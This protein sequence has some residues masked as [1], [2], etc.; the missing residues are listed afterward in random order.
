MKVRSHSIFVLILLM[1]AGWAPVQAQTADG[2]FVSIES[3]R[4]DQSLDTRGF[5]IGSRVTVEVSGVPQAITNVLARS[6]DIVLLLNNV[7]LFNL[8][9]NIVVS[10][11]GTDAPR[12][13]TLQFLLERNQ[14]NKIAWSA[15]L[16]APDASSRAA[17][18]EVGLA[19]A[20]SVTVISKAPVSVALILLPN[21]PL[22]RNYGWPMT[23]A[24][25]M[26]FVIG[27]GILIIGLR[28]RTIEGVLEGW[29][30]GAWTLFLCSLFFGWGPSICWFAFAVMFLVGFLYLANNT[31]LLRDSG[32]APPKNKHRPFSLARTQMAIWFYLSVSAFVFLWLMTGALD[33]IT[34]TILALMGIGAGTA[35]GAEAQQI[36]KLN[37]L[38]ADKQ[39]LE[40]K[41]T[42][43][44][45]EQ[46]DLK[47]L[48][49]L[50]TDVPCLETEKAN[51]NSKLRAITPNTN[52]LRA[53]NL[54][55]QLSEWEKY[56]KELPSQLDQIGKKL[57]KESDLK[58]DQ[59]AL[60]AISAPTA[61]E[62]ARLA[63]ISKLLTEIA[64]LR[65]DLS[66]LQTFVNSAEFAR[67][68]E[69]NDLLDSRPVSQGFFQDI[70]T[71]DGGISF[72]RFQL[73][74]W[75]VVLGIIFVTSVYKQLAM[76]DFNDT[77]LAL[78]GISS[79]TYMGFMFTEKPTN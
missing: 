51:L 59:T 40:V 31:D 28:S 76:P 66:L 54:Q 60:L 3:V 33:T 68:E 72:H 18:L 38:K 63:Q 57:S 35:L 11:Y 34:N 78:M 14:A 22:F 15:L 71:D 5:G 21:T 19:S 47:K 48:R 50:T 74:I 53:P 13:A 2:F 4:N 30:W 12:S 27:A 55:A 61:D 67:W 9:S 26:A 16:G 8:C 7:A 58:A 62:R 49:R 20:S 45:D 64:Q 52:T 1:T 77:L 79:G 39:A 41:S 24:R 46:C 56:W 42:L 44:P 6:K 37:K 25:I 10:S 65:A 73:F 23:T 29:I 17:K 36:G 70:L 32:P 69:I 43:T 75:T